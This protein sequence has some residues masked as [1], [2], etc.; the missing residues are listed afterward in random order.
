MR[1]FRSHQAAYCAELSERSEAVRGSPRPA[2][3]C[4]HQQL[5]EPCHSSGSGSLCGTSVRIWGI[6]TYR[7]FPFIYE[8]FSGSNVGIANSQ[9]TAAPF[10]PD[11][12]PAQ[13]SSAILHSPK[14]RICI[15]DFLMGMSKF[16][17]HYEFF[18]LNLIGHLRFSL[19]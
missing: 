15:H 13:Q 14:D 10:S 8:S 11:T 4:T 12:L 16:W 9:I 7:S 5:S 6:S 19:Y 3:E 18:F 1:S 17:F 2:R